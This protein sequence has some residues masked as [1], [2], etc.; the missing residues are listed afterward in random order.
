MKSGKLSYF[1]ILFVA[2]AL[3]STQCHAQDAP[4]DHSCSVNVGG[5]FVTPFGSDGKNFNTG[6][7]FQGGLGFA[8]TRPVEPRHGVRLYLLFDYM[9]DRL[10][11]TSAALTAAHG[12]A[13]ATAAHGSFSAVTFDPT[14]RFP[15]S[16][17]A[18]L[19]LSGGFG[20]FRRGVRFNSANPA[21]LTQPAG[22]TL[23]RLAVN[24]GAFD[25]GGGVNFGLT[26][27]GGV[28]LYAEG[29]VYRGF[30]V[31]G[32]TTLLPLTFGVRW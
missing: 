5:A 2:F 31:N 21:T 24:S 1:T 11:A 3:V 23:E 12:A 15:V 25:A 30:A 14:L 28:M 16:P 8:V 6:W 4:Q 19:Y 10:D 18:S 22:F 9:Y 26:R 27:N 32:G 17:R 29:R 20:W 13:S 7:G